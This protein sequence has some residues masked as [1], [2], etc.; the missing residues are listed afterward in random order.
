MI[1]IICGIKE[2]KGCQGIKCAIAP[3]LPINIVAANDESNKSS[4]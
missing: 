4:L 2:I 1:I 3:A